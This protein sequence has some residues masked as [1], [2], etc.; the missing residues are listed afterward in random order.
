ML[1]AHGF[2]FGVHVHVV[3]LRLYLPLITP[4]LHKLTLA[5]V[6]ARWRLALIQYVHALPIEQKS[7][8]ELQHWQ[9]HVAMYVQC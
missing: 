6:L 4:Q 9:I 7:K 3:E 5:A 1:H 2:R 8:R